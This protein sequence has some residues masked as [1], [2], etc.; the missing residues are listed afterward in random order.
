VYVPDSTADCNRDFFRPRMKMFPSATAGRMHRR[1]RRPELVPSISCFGPAFTT[2]VSPSS[3]VKRSLS[4]E[5]RVGD[6]GKGRPNRHAATFVLLP[7]PVFASRQVNTPPD[8]KSDTDSRHTGLVTERKQFLRIFQVTVLRQV[9]TSA[10]TES[11]SLYLGG[12]SGRD[13]DEIIVCDRAKVSRW[14]STPLCR[15]HALCPF[16]GS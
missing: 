16:P 9:A 12:K 13:K 2:N 4:I 3:L 8:R 15:H 6:A 10:P 1:V 11:P 14:L 5:G 7:S